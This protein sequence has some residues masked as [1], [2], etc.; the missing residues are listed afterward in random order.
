MSRAAKLLSRIREGEGEVVPSSNGNKLF[1]FETLLNKEYRDGLLGREAECCVDSIQ[2][3]KEAATSTE[4]ATDYHSMFP[5]EGDEIKGLSFEV[6]PQDLERLDTE[7]QGYNRYNV[8]LGSG[9]A[10]QVY[11]LPSEFE[12][13][14]DGS[15]FSGL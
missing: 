1:V 2:N 12:R 9:E 3:W 13:D 14:L 4:G 6:S 5:S 10:A 11:L 15:T 7:E 8:N